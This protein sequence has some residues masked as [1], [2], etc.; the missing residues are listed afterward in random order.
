[1]IKNENII[2]I[3][4]IDWDFI[5]QGH[6]EIMSIFAAKGN[7]VLFIENTGIR[8]PS[9]KD[10]PRIKKRLAAWFKSTKGFRKAG[11]NLYIY[12]PLI[13]PFPYFRLARRINKFLMLKALKNWMEAMDFHD[14]IIWTFLP[15]GIALDIIDFVKKKMLIYCCIADWAKLTTNPKGFK[16]AE[17]RLAKQSDLIFVQGEDFKKNCLRYNPNVYEFLFGINPVIFEKFKEDLPKVVPEDMRGLS[18]PIIGYVGGIHRH[19]DL[20]AIH[21][22]ALKEPDW[23]IVMIGPAQT[24]IHQFN[25][26]KNV[27]FIG[28]KDYSLLPSYIEQFDVGIVPYAINEYT[29]TVYPTKINEYH[30]MGK[31]VVSTALPEVVKFNKDNL[32]FIGKNKEEFLE[33]VRSAS[34]T[35]TKELIAARVCAAGENSWELKLEE[36]SGRMEAALRVKAVSS[37]VKWQKQFLEIYSRWRRKAIQVALSVVLLVGVIFYTP[38]M[39]YLAQPLKMNQ[40]PY[41]SDAI[42]VFAGGVGESGRAGEGYEERVNYAV[43]LYKKGIA[44][45]IIFS[46]GAQSVFPEPYV[47]KALA[48]SLGVPEG[49]II[50]EDKAANTYENV[51]KTARILESRGWKTIILVSSPYHMRRASLVF[52]KTAPKIGVVYSPAQESRFY[53]HGGVDENGKRVWKQVN[54]KQIKAII[55]EYAAICYY[56]IEGYI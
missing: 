54:L 40:S 6:Q 4:S 38:F 42:V 27:R 37:P 30:I 21:Y 11:E 19:V 48:V 23:T 46:S 25:G 50:L 49:A 24:P 5:W 12:S 44:K 43:E 18:R 17:A 28:K 14:P 55:H 35:N 33:K 56:W 31:P 9:L 15:T 41:S 47:M 36:M 22:M 39:W 7:R 13:L 51:K 20:E 3:S 26:I 10:I 1:M 34:K 52:R 53:H 8:P 32:V 2:C 16:N 29:R 45:N